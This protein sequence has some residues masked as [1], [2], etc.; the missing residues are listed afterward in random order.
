MIFHRTTFLLLCLFIA[1]CSG[2]A[3]S[4]GSLGYED[5]DNPSQAVGMIK[6][7]IFAAKS[8]KDE[9]QTRYPEMSEEFSANLNKWKTTE[10]E[11]IKKSEYHWSV[12]V[13][14]DPKLLEA[15]SQV[16]TA[17]K[18][19]FEILEKTRV[20][21]SKVAIREYC[22]NHFANLASGIWRQRTPR[23]YEYM[24]KAPSK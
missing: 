23:A 20:A 8:M 3:E 1:P 4:K 11:V 7:T 24:D 16:D 5:A 18:G 14:M 17:I 21:D 22:H 10:A 6:S 12:L 9:C 19:Y 13:K 2:L 15:P